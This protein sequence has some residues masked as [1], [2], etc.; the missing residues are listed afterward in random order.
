METLEAIK[1]KLNQLKPTLKSQYHVTRLGIFGSYVRGEQTAESDLDLLIEFE[2][3]FRFGLFTF[4]ELEHYLSD[5]LGQR[6]DL[7]MGDALKPAIGDRIL[8]EVI[9]L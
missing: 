5:L 9:Y 7:V 6:V 4:C 8:R 2:S 3:D 1:A